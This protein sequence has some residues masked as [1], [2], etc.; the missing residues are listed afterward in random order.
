MTELT[1]HFSGPECGFTYGRRLG[2]EEHP[3][4]YVLKPHLTTL[5]G[6]QI[7]EAK[8]TPDV[9]AR[10]IQRPFDFHLSCISSL[11]GCSELGDLLPTAW[12]DYF[13]GNSSGLCEDARN[14][15]PCPLRSLARLARD[16]D[17]V[18]LVEVKRIFP[19]DSHQDPSQDVE[20]RLLEI[21]KGQ[22]GKHLPRFPMDID[23][24]GGG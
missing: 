17:N 19:V 9:T 23:G 14:Y 6:G 3:N 15:G 22:P 18:L 2:L 8:V 20:F 4:R 5:G 10:E 24:D 1:D 7:L 11:V 13:V 21:L 16:M 12:E